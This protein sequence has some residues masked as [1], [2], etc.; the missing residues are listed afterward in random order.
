MAIAHA[1][2]WPLG[3]PMPKQ[4]GPVTFPGTGRTVW[5]TGRV[6]IGLRHQP[7]PNYHAPVPCSALW[8]QE[9]FLTKGTIA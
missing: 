3:F 2:T 5:W 8:V 9:L 6:A 7:A 1:S 4:P